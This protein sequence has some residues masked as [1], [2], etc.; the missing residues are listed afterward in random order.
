MLVSV[1]PT[2]PQSVPDPGVAVM[3]SVVLV[4]T[5]CVLG[6]LTTVIVRVVVM[7]IRR[8]RGVVTL[9]LLDV[10]TT[11]CCV[12][13]CG[14][15]FV[16]ST[17]VRQ[18]TAVLGL[19]FCTDP[20]NVETMLQRLLLLPLQCMAVM[21]TIPDIILGATTGCPVFPPC[22]PL[23][24]SVLVVVLRTASAPC[25]LLLVTWTTLLIVLLAT[26]TLPLRLRLSVTV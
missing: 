8:I 2:V 15:L 12:T 11:T 5:T 23:L 14:L 10:V 7:A 20:T 3:V 19:E 4:R 25:V 13:K 21:L 18:R 1:V 26:S 9:I 24:A 6:T 22:L 17:W 16:C